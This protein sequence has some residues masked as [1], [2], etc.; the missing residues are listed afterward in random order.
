MKK[1]AGIDYVTGTTYQPEEQILPLRVKDLEQ[2]NLS[3]IRLGNTP[4]K[5]IHNK[6]IIYPKKNF[7]TNNDA[8]NRNL[9]Q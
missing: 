6:F 4:K 3:L 7:V 1:N 9:P 8:I 5:E 2:F